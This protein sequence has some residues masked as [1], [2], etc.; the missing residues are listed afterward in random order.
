[1]SIVK[2]LHLSIIWRQTTFL[3][4]LASSGSTRQQMK[5]HFAR[6]MAVYAKSNTEEEL[7]LGKKVAKMILQ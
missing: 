6:V 1:M 2:S 4:I 3:F 5:E 7:D